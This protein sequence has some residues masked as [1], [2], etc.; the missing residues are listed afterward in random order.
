MIVNSKS[1]AQSFS[2]FT[3]TSIMFNIKN[4][5]VFILSVATIAITSVVGFGLKSNAQSTY[6]T[7]QPSP[8]YD[9]P[10]KV[11]AQNLTP[12]A[13]SLAQPVQSNQS[14]S[15]KLA[16]NE[17]HSQVAYVYDIDTG[18][19]LYE[20]NHYL[21]R[22]I[23][24]ITKLMTAMVVLDAEQELD[25]MLEITRDDIDTL[26]Y[27]HSRLA[28]G[29]KLS[30]R[31]LLLLALMSSENRAAS[32]LGRNYPGGLPAFVRAMNEKA[33]ALGMRHTVFVEPTGLSSE[34]LSTAPDLAKMLQAA[35][36]YPLIQRFSTSESYTVSPKPGQ[37][38][39]YV[40][41]NRLVANNDWQ[42]QV[43]KTG[44][45]NEAGRCLVLNTRL[46]NRNVAIVLLNAYGRYSGMGDANRIR[47]AYQ[48]QPALVASR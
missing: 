23:A 19:V 45:I 28:V 25:E 44:F 8:R 6:Q 35:A 47:Q 14:F 36:E 5:S 37:Q 12:V 3:H 22:P 20:K 48:K 18:E 26:K 11:Y 34:N 39:R 40:N 46:D 38:L 9:A 15:L 33:Q 42:I 13:A 27:T 10:Y 16:N 17:L 21:A 29:S 31:D 4:K 32:A 7:E 41:T 2:F 43:S 1:M 24:S 30:R